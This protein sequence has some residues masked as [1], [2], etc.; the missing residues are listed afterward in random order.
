MSWPTRSQT[1]GKICRWIRLGTIKR[2]LGSLEQLTTLKNVYEFS[3]CR[4]EGSWNVFLEFSW[5]VFCWA[6]GRQTQ[7]DVTKWNMG[8]LWHLWMLFWGMRLG[9]V[10]FSGLTQAT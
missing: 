2:S 4:F 9:N 10:W 8:L 7:E 5:Q 1:R 3:V 6:R